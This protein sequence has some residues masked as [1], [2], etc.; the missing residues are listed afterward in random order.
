MEQDALFAAERADGGDVLD[1]TDL[2][3]HEHHTDQ[4]GVRP[5]RCLEHQSK[6]QSVFLHIQVGHT[7]KP[8]RSSSRIVSSTALCSV[9]TVIRCLPLL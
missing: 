4:D 5:D 6:Q 8:W 9:F 7:S 2:V 3:V 1:H